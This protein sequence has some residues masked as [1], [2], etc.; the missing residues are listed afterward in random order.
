MKTRWSRWFHAAALAWCG[1]GPCACSKITGLGDLH[2]GPGEAGAACSVASDCLSGVCS[3]GSCQPAAITPTCSDGVSNGDEA[4][5]DCGGACAPC[6]DGSACGSAS[7]CESGL[8]LDG[9]CQARACAQGE[10]QACYTGS[11]ATLNVGACRAGVTT[12]L[13]DGSAFGPCV[14]EVTP[15][16]ER[17]TTSV[18]DD[19]NGVTNEHGL[20]CVCW[21]GAPTACPYSGPQGTEGVG[22]CQAGTKWCDALGTAYGPCSGEVTPQPEDCDDPADQDCAPNCGEEVWWM[23]FAHPSSPRLIDIDDTGRIYTATDSSNVS[24]FDASG[25]LFY[26]EYFGSAPV[27]ALEGTSNLVLGWHAGFGTLGVARFDTLSTEVW[28][29]YFY[30]APGVVGND[31]YALDT[32]QAGDVFVVGAACGYGDNQCAMDLGG[33]P[34]PWWGARDAFVARLDAAGDH[35]WSKSFGDIYLDEA[36]GVAATPD[37]G[38]VVTGRFMVSADFGGMTVTTSSQQAV[39]LVKLDADGNPLWAH[40]FGGG[41][42]GGL[43][44]NTYGTA[45]LGV[46]VD[47]SGDIVLMGTFGDSSGLGTIDLGGGPLISYGDD[48]TFVAKFDAMG[49]HLWS[50]HAD[51][52]APTSVSVNSFGDILVTSQSAVSSE[53]MLLD[54]GGAIKWSK[55][56][57]AFATYGAFAPGGDVVIA[58]DQGASAMFLTRLSR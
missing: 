41:A 32:N 10:T 26:D 42:A 20:G 16:P 4:G 49:N 25:N 35:V 2:F 55:V 27:F 13:D 30:N 8:C 15:T 56:M 47:P 57:N 58:G 52:D 19:C 48:D 1:L 36:R 44:P 33:G 18:D 22:I 38:L 24:W 5:I 54:A 6:A 31:V 29:K 3:N 9:V 7:D 17:C 21:P 37:G 39:F 51:I 45:G 53:V 34:L 28:S 40:A 46:R 14:G 12:C 11:P 43:P 23:A 50:M